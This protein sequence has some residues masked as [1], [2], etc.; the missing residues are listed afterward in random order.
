MKKKNIV[1]NNVEFNNIINVGKR[2]SSELFFV[3]M[4]ENS[5]LYNR[6]GIA[7]S[8]K[9]GNA[10]IRDK[11]KRQVKDI[12]DDIKINFNG[13][14]CIFIARPNIKKYDYQKIKDNMIYLTDK[15][16]EKNEK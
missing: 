2:F 10:V 3:Y 13:Y 7:I 14:D 12:I 4:L 6:Y 15:I 11:Y 9:I 16:G 5:F 1:K 8:K